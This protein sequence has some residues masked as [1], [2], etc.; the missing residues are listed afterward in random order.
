[1][2]ARSADQMSGDPAPLPAFTTALLASRYLVQ[3]RSDDGTE[4]VCR[5]LGRT[6]VALPPRPGGHTVFGPRRD[7]AKRTVVPIRYVVGFGGQPGTDPGQVVEL[8][9]GDCTRVGVPSTYGVGPV[10]YTHLT[11]PTSDLV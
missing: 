6:F 3:P 5:L 7:W 10:S 8:F 4:R 2:W 9:D 11:L 1:M